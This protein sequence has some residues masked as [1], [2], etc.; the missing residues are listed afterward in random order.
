MKA[1]FGFLVSLSLGCCTDYWVTPSTVEKCP[2]GIPQGACIT[3]SDMVT[4]ISGRFIVNETVSVHF[5]PGLRVPTISGWIVLEKYMHNVSIIGEAEK[6]CDLDVQCGVVIKCISRKIGLLFSSVSRLY[7]TNLEI[8]DCGYDIS[9]STI[10][11]RLKL[12]SDIRSTTSIL[13]DS[14]GEFNLNSMSITNSTGF[15]L[16][17]IGYSSDS[18]TTIQKSTLQYGNNNLK[19]LHTFD[20]SC[21]KTRRERF[22]YSY[23]GRHISIC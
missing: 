10:L 2:S 23:E 11:S 20:F 1:L 5:L 16:L 21:R 7:L 12:G 18:K 14:V 15:G 9:Q 3:I 22:H 8:R 17:V 13:A 6:D 4:G 19:E